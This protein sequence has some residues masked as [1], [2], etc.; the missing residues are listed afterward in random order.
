MTEYDDCLEEVPGESLG[1]F[2]AVRAEG[3]GST[4]TNALW[5]FGVAPTTIFSFEN[6]NSQSSSYRQSRASTVRVSWQ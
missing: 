6:S 3:V 4:A 2:R 5:T 1:N